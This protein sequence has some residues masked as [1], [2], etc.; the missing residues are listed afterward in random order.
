MEDG[1]QEDSETEPDTHRVV[2]VNRLPSHGRVSEDLPVPRTALA[3]GAHADDIELGCGATL[4][5]WAAAGCAVHMVILTDGSKGTWDPDRDVASLVAARQS[6]QR[7]AA[8]V[9][10]TENVSF[11]GRPDGE[12]RNTVREQWDVCRSIRQVR[13]EVVLGHDPWRPYQL[14]PDHRHAGF[15]LADAI[16][17]ARDPLFFADQQLAPHRPAALLLWEAGEPNHIERVGETAEVKVQALLAHQSQ[18]RN[19]LGLDGAVPSEESVEALRSRIR[20]QLAEHGRLTGAP[21][22]EAYHLITAL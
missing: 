7:A 18:Y 3:V 10:G 15:I 17:A 22:A 11:L 20:A 6:E 4:A 16:V 19:T 5:K 12:L 14:H 2:P 21:A 9:I 13:P 8:A 1:A